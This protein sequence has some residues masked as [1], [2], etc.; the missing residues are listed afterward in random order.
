MKNNQFP[1]L[2]PENSLPE[3]LPEHN[4]KVT[5][6]FH[7][8]IAVR[9]TIFPM[10]DIEFY[11][12][13]A[14][15]EISGNTHSDPQTVPNSTHGTEC[16]VIGKQIRIKPRQTLRSIFIARFAEIFCRHGNCLPHRNKIPQRRIDFNLQRIKHC[17]CAIRQ[18]HGINFAAQCRR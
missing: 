15:R 12:N 1:P 5:E 11:R 2:E 4:M 16:G 13:L 7:I 3:V 10:A 9:P 17:I 18:L 6:W 14:R 8:H